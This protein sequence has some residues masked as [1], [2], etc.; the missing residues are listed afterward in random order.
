MKNISLWGLVQ[1]L[2]PEIDNLAKVV[3]KTDTQDILLVVLRNCPDLVPP[4]LE[5]QKGVLEPALSLRWLRG[6]VLTTNLLQLPL[7]PLAATPPA[8]PEPLRM[9]IVPDSI[10]RAVASPAVQ[11]PHFLVAMKLLQLLCHIFDR[12]AELKQHVA[13]IGAPLEWTK[14]M[15]IILGVRTVLSNLQSVRRRLPDL[16]PIVSLRARLA[17]EDTAVEVKELLFPL[18]VKALDG[19]VRHIPEVFAS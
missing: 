17:R 18:L 12:I 6:V 16:S 8:N 5:K 2:Q 9:Y 1:T 15:T 7:P 11:S 3:L 10:T 4:Y 14:F 13:E 19:F